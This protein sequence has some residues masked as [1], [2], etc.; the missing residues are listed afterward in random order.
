MIFKKNNKNKKKKYKYKKLSLKY[1]L[2]SKSW[3]K[4]F[5][6]NKKY[7]IFKKNDNIIN[8]GSSPGGWTKLIKEKIKIKGKIFCCD[9]LKS[10]KINN[11]K[12]IKGNICNKKIFNLIIKKTKKYKINNIISDISPN[13]TGINEI[14]DPKNKKIIKTILNLCKKKLIYKGNLIIKIFLG[15]NFSKFFKKIKKMFNIIKI[16]KPKSSSYFSKEIYIIAKKYKTNLK[17]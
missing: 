13:I 8:L 4:L 1:N 2:I 14:D 17:N 12:F 3:F 5:E 10:K 16:F 7:K 6:I 11:V 9:I 15:K